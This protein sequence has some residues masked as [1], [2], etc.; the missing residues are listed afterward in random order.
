M[1][2]RNTKAETHMK[3]KPQILRIY[4]NNVSRILVLSN[5]SHLKSICYQKIISIHF[6]IALWLSQFPSIWNV[7][8]N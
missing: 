3:N 1:M 8:G 6:M 4:Q 5:G 2:Y 7:T